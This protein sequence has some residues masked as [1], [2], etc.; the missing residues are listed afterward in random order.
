MLE[1]TTLLPHANPGTMSR[2]E[3]AADCSRINPSMGLMLES[4]SA[5]RLYAPGGAHEFA[6]S[7]RPRVRLRTIETGR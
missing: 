1:E 4:T 6:P 2:R 3:M 7:K 5:H